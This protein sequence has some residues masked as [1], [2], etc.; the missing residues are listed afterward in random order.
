MRVY[1]VATNDGYNLLSLV[2]VFTSRAHAE[3][4]GET[5][6]AEDGLAD[7]MYIWECTLD[8]PNDSD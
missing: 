6:V 3:R 5:A 4:A 7:G 2:G 8:E 1:V